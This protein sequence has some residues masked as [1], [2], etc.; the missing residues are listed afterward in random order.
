MAMHITPK[1]RPQISMDG[2]DGNVYAIIG[3]VAKCL[4]RA[5]QR[6]EA[7]AFK[8]AAFKCQSYDEVLQLTMQYVEWV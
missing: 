8:D 2:V 1:G 3:H 6:D 7:K 5:G 4:E